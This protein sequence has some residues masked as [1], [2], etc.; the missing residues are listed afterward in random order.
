MQL[1]MDKT[2]IVE[3]MWTARSTQELCSRKYMDRAV[4]KGAVFLKLLLAILQEARFREIVFLEVQKT[5][6]WLWP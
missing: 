2:N 1:V 5:S 3:N 6:I 4:H